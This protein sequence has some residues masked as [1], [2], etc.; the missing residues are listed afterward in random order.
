MLDRVVKI[1]DAGE[2]AL[3]VFFVELANDFSRMR[4]KGHLSADMLDSPDNFGLENWRMREGRQVLS[5]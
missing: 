4:T 5:C 1:A 3:N 2:D